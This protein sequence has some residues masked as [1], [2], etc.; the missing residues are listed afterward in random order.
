MIT[1]ERLCVYISTAC[2]GS[3]QCLLKGSLRIAAG[4][5]RCFVFDESIAGLGLVPLAFD[6]VT[7]SDDY[8]RPDSIT[9]LLLHV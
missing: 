4:V 6:D 5:G 7:A 9:G 3:K 1:C 2:K 8:Y